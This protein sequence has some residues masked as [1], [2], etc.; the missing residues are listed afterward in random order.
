MKF[1]ALPDKNALAS[2]HVELLQKHK[3]MM[4]GL[5]HIAIAQ[6]AAGNLVAVDTGSVL[7]FQILEPGRVG[8][9]GDLKMPPR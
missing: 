6:L 4:T 1:M 3:N 5:D 2:L 7:R 9:R 8:K